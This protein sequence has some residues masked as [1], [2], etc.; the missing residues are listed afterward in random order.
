MTLR[1]YKLT[2]N[3]HD[4]RNQSPL[5]QDTE[6]LQTTPALYDE[7]KATACWTMTLRLYKLPSNHYDDRNQSPLDQETE[8]L[9]T[10]PALYDEGKAEH[11]GL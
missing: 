4:D 6:T 8:T 2:S 7:G 10:T 5:D 3:L 11:F 9:Q 1:L